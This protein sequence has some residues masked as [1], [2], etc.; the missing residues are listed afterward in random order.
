MIDKQDIDLLIV[1]AGPVG[2]T[3]AERAAKVKGW[4]A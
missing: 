4:K 1:G 2:C 3:I